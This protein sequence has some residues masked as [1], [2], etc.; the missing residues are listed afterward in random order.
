MSILV[1]YHPNLI[2][3]DLLM[4]HTSGYSLCKFLRKTH[5]FR[6][7]SIIILT[8][9][10]GIIDRTKAKLTGASD[11]FFN[12]APRSKKNSGYDSKICQF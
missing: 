2:F 4:P 5:Q 1:K 10:D 9:Q 11:F 7:T 6:E 12:Q 3:L 8:G